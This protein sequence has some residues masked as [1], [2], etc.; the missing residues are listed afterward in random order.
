[1]RQR[2]WLAYLV[3]GF[4]LAGLYLFGPSALNIGPVFNAIGAS[5]TRAATSTTR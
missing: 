3:A 5:S 4:S 2:A 1:M